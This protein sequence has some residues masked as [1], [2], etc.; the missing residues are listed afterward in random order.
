MIAGRIKKCVSGGQWAM[1]SVLE[2]KSEVRQDEAARGCQAPFYVLCG[3]GEP[4]VRVSEGRTLRQPTAGFG[5]MGR[6]SERVSLQWWR[7]AVHVGGR[8]THPWLLTRGLY[9][10]G[11]RVSSMYWYL[12]GREG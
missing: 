9:F 1:C 2:S 10:G 5:S 6:P 8:R 11:G 12:R 4:K 3:K 7:V